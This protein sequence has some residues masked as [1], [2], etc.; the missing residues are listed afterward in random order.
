MVEYIELFE[1]VRTDRVGKEFKILLNLKNIPQGKDLSK[2]N[3]AS[4]CSFYFSSGDAICNFIVNTVIG[5]CNGQSYD[6]E[7]TFILATP[8]NGDYNNSECVLNIEGGD[9]EVILLK[10]QGLNNEVCIYYNVIY[11][12][13]RFCSPVC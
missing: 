6:K 13:Y 7:Y 10:M 5:N 11:F 2:K 1:L 4:S 9:S 3:D 12:Q 8:Y